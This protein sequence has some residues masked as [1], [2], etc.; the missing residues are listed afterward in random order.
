MNTSYNKNLEQT[1]VF[2]DKDDNCLECA[3]QEVCPLI[4][5]L[6]HE[7]AFLATYNEPIE[8]CAL[9]KLGNNMTFSLLG[10][11]NYD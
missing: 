5:A 9:S 8:N 2:F 6:Q 7:K 10:D 1:D 4:S 3:F 11:I